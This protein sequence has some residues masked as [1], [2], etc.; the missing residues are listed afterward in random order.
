M[1]TMVGLLGGDPSVTDLAV[2]PVTDQVFPSVT[3][4]AVPLETDQVAPLVI[5]QVL[6]LVTDQVVLLEIDQI[7]PSV[8]DQADPLVIHSV[9]DQVIPSVTDQAVQYLLSMEVVL[10]HLTAFPGVTTTPSIPT[11]T[12]RSQLANWYVANWNFLTQWTFFPNRN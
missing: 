6:P 7:L 4:Q 9:T 8:T 1:V 5:D 10:D 2:P 3:V 11:D 12:Q